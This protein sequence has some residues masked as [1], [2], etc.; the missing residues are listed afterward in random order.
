MRIIKC[1]F[2]N[3]YI[4]CRQEEC[5]ILDNISDDQVDHALYPEFDTYCEDYSYVADGYPWESLDDGD[6]ADEEE[7]E[8]SRERY[9][10]DCSWEWEE[11]TLEELKTWCAEHYGEYESHFAERVAAQMARET[12]EENNEIL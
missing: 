6:F 2:E 10:E 8:A 12:T 7:M 4:G 1:C 3:G 5:Y 9:Y 11:I